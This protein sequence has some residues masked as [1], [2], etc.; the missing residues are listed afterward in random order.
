[1]PTQLFLADESAHAPADSSFNAITDQKWCLGSGCTSRLCKDSESFVNAWQ[2]KGSIKLAS[3]TTVA[4]IAKGDVEITISNGKQDKSIVR[5]NTLYVPDLRAN[6]LSVAKIVDKEHQV[7]FAKNHAYVR[8][9]SEKVKMVADRV[10]DLFYLRESQ[11]RA[12]AAARSTPHSA[13]EWHQ[14]LGHL[15]WKD[16]LSMLQGRLVSGMN[17]HTSDA[18]HTF[19]T[20]A[21]GKITRLPFSKRGKRTT[22]PFKI[23]HADVCGP[24]RNESQG[25]A[26]YFLTFTNDF[27]RW[28][29]VYF[30]KNKSEVSSKFSEYRHYA[31][32][33][34][35]RKVKTLQSDNGKEFCNA[36]MNDILKILGI[37]RP[38][39]TPYTPQQNGAAEYAQVSVTCRSSVPEYTSGIRLTATINL[40]RRA[41]KASSSDIPRPQKPIVYGYPPKIREP[42]DDE[43]NEWHDA[44]FA[45][46]AE[47]P[48]HSAIFRPEGEEWRDAIYSKTKSLIQNNT[49]DIVTRPKNKRV[50]KCRTVLRNKYKAG[51]SLDRRKERIVAR[52]FSQRPGIDF[53]EII[54]PVARFRSFRLLTALDTRFDLK[55]TQLDVETAYLNGKVDAE[56][57]METSELVSEMLKRMII[58]KRDIQVTKHAHTMLKKLEEPNAVCRLSQTGRRWHA[59]FDEK[60]R[61]IGLTPTHAD[62]RV[63]VDTG[64]LT[65]IL[66]YVDDILIISNDRKRESGIKKKLS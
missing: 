35:G 13:K 39:S 20:C 14:R 19:D 23:I 62:T 11:D 6:L 26:R 50:I 61:S 42:G 5:Q 8:D 17:F 32:T 66:V 7:L 46:H 30:L 65:F 16:M 45:M 52:G 55:I 59:E 18:L 1:M 33:Q 58:E 41:L 40:R 36:K 56:I 9:A 28:T 15:N 47:I 49:F 10:G 34:T 21:A 4:A 51:G 3:D 37:R 29:K 53:Y 24:M 12:Y 43:R 2:V 63:Y 38:L 48:L 25:H 64:N 27:S 31:E 22:A 54:A 60:L 57:F 44:E